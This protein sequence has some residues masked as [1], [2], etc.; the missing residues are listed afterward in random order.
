MR[1][2]LAIARARRCAKGDGSERAISTPAATRSTS[3]LMMV[4]LGPVGVTEPKS[5]PKRLASSRPKS[6]ATPMGAPAAS[7]AVS[8]KLLILSPT[9]NLPVGM[10]SLMAVLV[11]GF[12]DQTIQGP[13]LYFGIMNLNWILLS[14]EIIFFTILL[15]S[16]SVIL[17][18]II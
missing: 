16:L 6:G 13:Q 5:T 1:W 15:M 4:S 18:L 11:G 12:K 10:N 7:R 8:R 3:A 9:R 14:S 2:G 17:V